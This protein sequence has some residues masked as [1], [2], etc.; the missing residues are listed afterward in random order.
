[1]ITIANMSAHAGS[2]T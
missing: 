2:L 1:M